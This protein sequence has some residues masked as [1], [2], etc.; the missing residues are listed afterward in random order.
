[1]VHLRLP[2]ACRLQT[3]CAAGGA[4]DPPSIASKE[5]PEGPMNF[6]QYVKQVARKPGTAADLSEEDAHDLFCA[7]L[8]GGVPDLELAALLVALHLKGESLGE[9]LGFHR[10]VGERLYRLHPP[11]ALRRPLVI[12]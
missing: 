9:L 7:M 5:F 2:L 12:P 11:D 1:R 6:A 8:D 10:A 3:R 4:C